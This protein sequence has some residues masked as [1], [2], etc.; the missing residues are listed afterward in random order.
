[1]PRDKRYEWSISIRDY[2]GYVAIHRGKDDW[3]DM[4]RHAEV[5][6]MATDRDSI[7]RFWLRQPNGTSSGETRVDMCDDPDDTARECLAG[8]YETTWFEKPIRVGDGKTYLIGEI[9]ETFAPGRRKQ[10]VLDLTKFRL[11]DMLE[12][13]NEPGG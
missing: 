13:A 6:F 7:Y 2:Q 8:Q 4:G 5:T 11:E 3:M 12:D 10:V 1:M 9:R